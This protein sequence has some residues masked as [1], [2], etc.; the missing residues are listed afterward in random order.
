MRKYT[1]EAPVTVEPPEDKTPLLI[2][3]S[4]AAQ[5]ENN[6]RALQVL[7]GFQKAMAEQSAAVQ[8]LVESLKPQA[9]EIDIHVHARD[10]FNQ[11]THYKIKVK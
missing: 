7:E 2:A 1:S 4:I 3:Q 8:K 9:K 10:E 6:A 11:P 5:S